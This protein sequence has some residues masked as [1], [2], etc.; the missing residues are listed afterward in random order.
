MPISV[1]F[2]SRFIDLIEELDEKNKSSVARQMGL[3]YVTFSKVC[4][5]GILP[6]PVIL[7]RIADFFNVSVE[8][9]LAKTDNDY[10]KTSQ[11]PASF[12]DRLEELAS[13]REIKNYCELG[14][15]LHI[16]R[17]SL[18][19]WKKE[20]YLPSLEILE[21]IADYF[22]VSIDYLLGRTDDRNN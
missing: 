5:Y 16:H 15:R 13:E 8:Y 11:S 20:N 21:L 1:D 2:Q 4:N 7:V 18:Y 22:E 10:F 12:I 6:K 14:E 9:L 3:N 17:N 19:A